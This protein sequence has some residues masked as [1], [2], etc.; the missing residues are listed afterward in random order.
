VDNTSPGVSSCYECS[1]KGKPPVTEGKA[2][3]E[4][5]MQVVDVKI[6]RRTD[7]A[8]LIAGTHQ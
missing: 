6:D 7:S 4:S 1:G 5:G 2:T 3:I 8:E